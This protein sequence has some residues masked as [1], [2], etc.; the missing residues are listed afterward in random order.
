VR[1]VIKPH[2]VTAAHHP[3]W[4]ANWRALAAADPHVH[5]IDDPAADVMPYLQAADVLVS[6]ASS[7]IF[8]YLALDRPIVLVTNPD[9]RKVGHFDPNGIEWRWRDVGAEVHDVEA[10]PAAV[11]AALDDPALGEERR[12]HYRRQ[13]FGDYTDGC[14]AER[15]ARKITELAL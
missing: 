9:R 4:L 6:D 15:I 1:L 7:V 8:L 12:A 10:L 3:D 11:S 2:P 14:A 5:L 13:L